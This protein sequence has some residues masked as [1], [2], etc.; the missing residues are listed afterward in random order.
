MRLRR[1][2]GVL[3]S[4][5]LRKLCLLYKV[6]YIRVTHPFAG[7]Q[8]IPKLSLLPLDLHVLS[9]SLAFILSQ[10]QTLHCK[11]FFVLRRLDSKNQEVLFE[12][13]TSK[14][15]CD[16]KTEVLMDP[17][18]FLKHSFKELF[19]ESFRFIQVSIS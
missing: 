7:R 1:K 2:Y 8:R 19:N 4:E 13:L 15:I 6:D 11:R 3:I 14:L 18:S 12:P 17:L 5:F 10:D 9:L 16:I